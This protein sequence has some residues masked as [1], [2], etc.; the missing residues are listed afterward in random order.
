M[1]A[2]AKILLVHVHLVEDIVLIVTAGA[3]ATIIAYVNSYV[4]YEKTNKTN[5]TNK[6]YQ[7]VGSGFI[8]NGNAS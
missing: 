3:N 1:N 6:Y 8:C 5:K 7:P 2:C 4:K